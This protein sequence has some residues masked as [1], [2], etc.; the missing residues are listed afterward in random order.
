MARLRAD[1]PGTIVD[2]PVTKITDWL[3]SSA[4]HRADLLEMEL[5][6][7]ATDGPHHDPTTQVRI[8]I[9]PSGTE[10]KAKIYLEA[11]TPNPGNV[12]TERRRMRALLDAIAEEILA[13]LFTIE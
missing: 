7:A 2:R 8:C 3:D 4:P 13:S 9:R 11:V 1:P 10:P 6:S 5:A 12:S